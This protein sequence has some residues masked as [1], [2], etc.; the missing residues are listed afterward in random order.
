[1]VTQ[2]HLHKVR[3]VLKDDY[4]ALQRQ[5]LSYRLPLT[6]GMVVT[7]VYDKTLRKVPVCFD[8]DFTC[9]PSG[10]NAANG[11]HTNATFM[12]SGASP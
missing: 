5:N 6:V 9:T 11:G 12:A 2:S 4:K 1:M 7:I 10:A 8:E 3:D